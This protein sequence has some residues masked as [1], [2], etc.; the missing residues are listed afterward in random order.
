[1]N[2]AVE[3]RHFDITY[4]DDGVPC[5][6]VFARIY[7]SKPSAIEFTKTNLAEAIGFGLDHINQPQN[8]CRNNGITFDINDIYLP[9]LISFLTSANLESD[10]ELLP[11][12]GS[13]IIVNCNA[14]TRHE[15]G[16]CVP[17]ITLKDDENMA[18]ELHTV[19]QT[20][21]QKGNHSADDE[22]NQAINNFYSL[23]WVA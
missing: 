18:H 8:Q 20:L 7:M 2:I 5:I 17:H 19:K 3:P 16:S 6:S 4:T 10:I 21:N 14:H 15:H 22:L 13:D 12:E 23:G 11:V 1:M 9:S